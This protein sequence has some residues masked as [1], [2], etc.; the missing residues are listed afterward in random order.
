MYTIFDRYFPKS[1]K[2]D[3]RLQRVDGFRR[4]HQ[5]AR[6]T[7]LPAKEVINEYLLETFTE[8]KLLSK[9]IVTS[10]SVI[11]EETSNGVRQKRHD[12]KTSFD[13]ADCI[14]PRG[15]NSAI[16]LGKTNITGEP[17]YLCEKLNK[18]FYGAVHIALSSAQKFN[19]VSHENLIRDLCAIAENGAQK[20]I[21]KYTACAVMNASRREAKNRK[22]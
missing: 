16:L 21:I 12:L 17:V 6:N 5:I 4:V 7:P 13:E 2:S 3:T 18:E 20:E 8:K 10:N 1:I 11:P 14:I 15:V 22:G 9:L 19:E